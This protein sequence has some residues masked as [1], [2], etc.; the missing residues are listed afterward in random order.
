MF[1][2]K[3]FKIH[4]TSLADGWNY[5]KLIH[6][7]GFYGTMSTDTFT[8][9]AHNFIRIILHSPKKE[10]R[11]CPRILDPIEMRLFSDSLARY[12]LLE[13]DC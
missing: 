12:G 6:T 13:T 4:I 2:N 7:F 5:L 8:T 11:L 10:W 9:D 1:Q 3:T